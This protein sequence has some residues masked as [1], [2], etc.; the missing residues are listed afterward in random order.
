MCVKTKNPLGQIFEG[1]FW[2]ILSTFFS[3]KAEAAPVVSFRV[4]D[5]TNIVVHAVDR[6]YLHVSKLRGNNLILT[7]FSFIPW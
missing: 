4:H 6:E 5:V 3:W 1:C 7:S 2:T